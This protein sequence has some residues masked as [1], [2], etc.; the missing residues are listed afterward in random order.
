MD[1]VSIITNAIL[2]WN[3]TSHVDLFN[4]IFEGNHQNYIESKLELFDTFEQFWYG[5]DNNLKQRFVQLVN[6]KYPL[7]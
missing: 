4:T 1:Q 2:Y 7:K 6:A 5:L 3:N